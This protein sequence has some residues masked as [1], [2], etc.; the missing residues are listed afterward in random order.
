[1]PC[2]RLHDENIRALFVLCPNGLEKCAVLLL[3]NFFAFPLEK[4][5]LRKARPRLVVA[6]PSC[7]AWNA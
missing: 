2:E 7:L 4:E 6:A 1:M 3:S 5:N